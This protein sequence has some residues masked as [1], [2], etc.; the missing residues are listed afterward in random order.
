MPSSA[1]YQAWLDKNPDK[2]GTPDYDTIVYAYGKAKEREAKTPTPEPVIQDPNKPEGT[3]AVE[4][5]K[6]N[7]VADNA[8]LDWVEGQRYKA[9]QAGKSDDQFKEEMFGIKPFDTKSLEDYFNKTLSEAKAARQGEGEPKPYTFADALDDGWGASVTGLASRQKLPETLPSGASTLETLGYGFGVALGDLPAMVAGFLAGGGPITGGAGA[10]ALPAGIRAVYIDNLQNGEFK[11]PK[12]FLKRTRDIFLETSKAYVTGAVATATGRA[13]GAKL[14]VATTITG[15]TARTLAIGTTEALTATAV[16]GALEGQLPTTQDFFN[17]AAAVFAIGAIGYTA[18][19]SPVVVKKIQNIYAKT[20]LHP[21]EVALD[22]QLNP[23]I[24]ADLMSKDVDIPRAYQDAVDPMFAPAEKPAPA[25]VEPKSSFLSRMKKTISVR[26]NA[27]YAEIVDA[28]DPI[29]TYVKEAE[30]VLGKPLSSEQNPFKLARLSKGFVGKAQYYLNYGTFS[31]ATLENK[32]KSFKDIVAKI[33]D[34]GEMENFKEYI[35]AARGK[36]LEDRGIQTGLG[37][38]KIDETLAR[39]GDKYKQ[40]AQDLYDFQNTLT[41]YLRDSGIL[42]Q[43][44]YDAMVASNKYYVPFHRLVGEESG[45]GTGGQGLETWN[46]IK[47]IKGSELEIID[48]IESIIKNVYTYMALAE[49]NRAALAFVDLAERFTK[50]GFK[51]KFD[52]S[53]FTVL[54]IEKKRTPVKPIDVKDEEMVAFLKQQGMPDDIIDEIDTTG[55]TVFRAMRE[56]VA[57]NEIAVMRAGKREVYVLPPE[58]AAAFKSTD[59]TTMSLLFQL[60]TLPAKLSRAGITLAPQFPATNWV[61]D[62]FDAYINSKTGYNPFVSA[63]SGLISLV[64]KDSYYKENLKAGGFQASL[65]S[66]D[67]NYIKNELFDVNNKHGIVGHAWNVVKSP[68]D[69]FR[70]LSQF[71]DEITRLGE[72]KRMSKQTEGLPS[73]KRSVEI[74]YASREVLPDLSQSGRNMALKKWAA[75]TAFLNASIQGLDRLTRQWRTNPGQTAMRA[76]TAITIPSVA[77]WYVNHKDPRYVNAPDWQKNL[78]W[79]VPTDDWQ[80]ATEYDTNFPEYLQRNNN[81]V[82]EVNKGVVFKIPKPREYGIIF[83]SSVERLLDKLFIDDQEA[84]S[85]LDAL[86]ESITPP[87]IPTVVKPVWEETTNKSMFTGGPL[88]SPNVEAAL[89]E[90]QYTN[91]TTELTKWFGSVLAQYPILYSSKPG[92]H[93]ISPAVMENYVR[94]WTG[95]LGVMALKITDFALREAELLP[96]PPTPEYTLADIPVIQAFVVRNP[97]AQAGPIIRF[98]DGYAARQQIINTYQYYKNND[99]AKLE[100]FFKKYPE[101]VLANAVEVRDA[102]NTHQT[103]IRNLWKN[104]KY[105]PTEKRQIIDSLYYAMI[106]MAREGNRQLSELDKAAAQNLP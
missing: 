31:Y 28:F 99:P 32:G 45:M 103:I 34:D 47:A 69:Y 65:V 12:D 35:I 46:P 2:K 17:S 41:E 36:E 29:N 60:T 76:V 62:Q 21:K 80:P 64:K 44:A 48:P 13:V 87:L 33:A 84:L 52:D 56:P 71:S 67:T 9:N 30:R 23:E 73:L 6:A 105:N 98:H 68:L 40:A 14:P 85:A 39:Y 78:F 94:Q 102:L 106:K 49:K 27:A 89:P 79:L 90:V 63:V 55:L 72:A 4:R 86:M 74:G 61:R 83:G 104:P 93:T 1:E 88:V 92:A 75:H 57:D 10:F 58:L 95:T 42:S 51:H 22:A 77:L 11:D 66:M 16:T 100:A 18:K 97:S 50:G 5:L 25:A 59:L 96:D 37:V 26:L 53:S 19:Q 24:R 7:G 8:I 81:G 101:N 91:Y 38:D 70:M 3:R 43:K 15:S 20:G 82:L 54:A